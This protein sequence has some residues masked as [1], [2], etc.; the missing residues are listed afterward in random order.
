LLACRQR[1]ARRALSADLSYDG[2]LVFP[3]FAQGGEP[4]QKA[5]N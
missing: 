3:G 1:R 2:Q 4:W 5:K